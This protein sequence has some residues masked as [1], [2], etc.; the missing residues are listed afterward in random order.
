MTRL[1]VRAVAIAATLFL[2][3]CS[4]L[5][6]ALTAHVDIAARAGG[7]ELSSTRLAQLMTSSAQVPARK[8][9]AVAIA[10][11]WVNYQLLGQ[12]GAHGDTALSEKAIDNAMWAQI[13]QA[14]SKKFYEAVQ[15]GF[16]PADSS[17]YEKMYNDGA[18]LAAR[19][20]LFMASAENMKPA[21]RDSVR[22][23]AERIARQVTSAN[24]AEMAKKYSADGSKDQGGDLGLFQKGQM[25][26]PFEQ[27]LLALKPGE[28]S[29][30][31]E[32]QFGYHIIRRPTYAEV[33]DKF[34]A[35]YR[36]TAD[37]ANEQKYLAELE[38]TNK[39]EVKPG[40]AKLVKAIAE[41]LDAY[42]DD[43]SVIATSRGGDISAA[44]LAQWIAAF[45]PQAQIRQQ[46]AAAP[47]S[48]IPLFVTNV[49]R[50]ELVLHAADSAKIALD[51][52]DAKGIRGAFTTAYFGALDGLNL[53]PAK[54]AD[55][56]KTTAEKE[57]LA[58]SRVEAYL[59][60]L[61]AQKARFVDVAEPVAIALRSKYEARVV[62]AGVDRA[63]TAAA[64][65]KAKADSAKKAAMPASVV[66]MPGATPPAP[67]A[68]APKAD[69]A[70]PAAKK[71]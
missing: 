17:Q 2:A 42:R 69:S 65:I 9:V 51:T 23:V 8:D 22:K 6:D 41:D 47:D 20:I 67:A 12:A 29:P 11:L 49:M 54:L 38:K 28:I 53:T 1:H 58:A 35:T 52:A 59:E 27:G 70:K 66:P 68:A 40:T 62:T 30:V 71:P 26:P 19:H 50:N 56:A 32:S 13:A 3:A 10:N 46:I 31:V 24:F 57:R 33:K 64:A 43:R 16:G 18:M 48:Q 7:Q 61:I 44:R 36:Q 21:Q 34:S 25:V 55:S 14:R 63:V 5:K 4:G 39:I 15:K 60:A 37:Q 45:P